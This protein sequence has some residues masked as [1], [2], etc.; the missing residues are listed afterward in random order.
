VRGVTLLAALLLTVPTVAGC[1]SDQE[2]A[3]GSPQRIKIELDSDTEPPLERV[4]VEPGEE[5]ELVITSDEAGE[6]HI[7]STPEDTVPYSAGTTTVTI[8][9]DQPGVVDVERHEP[10]ALVLQ[11]QV[12]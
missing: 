7:H 11:L 2:P 1:G 3:S 12:G 4:E 5:V 9:I 6:L 10:E 8:S